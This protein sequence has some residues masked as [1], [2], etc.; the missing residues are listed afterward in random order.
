LAGPLDTTYALPVRPEELARAEML[1]AL[2]STALRDL[3][4]GASRRRFKAGQVV[5]NEGDS[6]NSLHVVRRGHLKVVRPTHDDRLVLDRIEPGQAFGELAVLN[7]APRL[8]SVIALEDCETIEVS[9]QE[10]ERVLE[11]HPGAVRRMLGTLARSLTLAKEEVARHNRHLEGTVRERTSDLRESQL[12]VVRRLSHAAESRDHNTGLHI[13]RMTRLCSR[14]AL[15]AGA[16]PDMAEMLL[17]AAPMHD[18]G[19]IGIPDHIL[20][21]PGKLDA[22]EWEIMKSH[23]AIGAEL[24]AGSRSPVVQMGEL[25]SLTH[26]EKWDGSGYPRGLKGNEIPFVAR[27]TSVCDVFDALISERPYKNAWTL[28]AAI[29]EIKADSGSHFDPELV[30]VF[31]SIFPELVSIVDE[32]SSEAGV[33]PPARSGDAA[34]RAE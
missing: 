13:T 26:H 1:E 10:F 14:L 32:A 2:P 25:I 5:F 23:A 19:K 3:A 4:G 28:E 12:E 27:I 9:K 7:S 24:L 20:L 6:G 33:P 18:V 30:E 31:V 34:D 16:S 22:D 8:A 15:A 11:E 29:E 21:K 17:N